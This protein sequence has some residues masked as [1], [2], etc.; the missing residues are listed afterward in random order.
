MPGISP[1]RGGSFARALPDNSPTRV[2]APQPPAAGPRRHGRRCDATRARPGRHVRGRWA[3]RQAKDRSKRSQSPVPERRAL[4]G[5]A[6]RRQGRACGASP[7]DGRQ[8]PTLAPGDLYRPSRPDGEGQARGQA[9]NARGEPPQP[10]SCQGGGDR[11]NKPTS[12]LLVNYHPARGRH[13]DPSR[14]SGRNRNAETPRVGSRT[15]CDFEGNR[16]FGRC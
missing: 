3:G 10:T 11:R 6:L 4:S 2:A 7:G 12:G 9:R 15:C 13:P 5:A 14:V 1:F 8:A 16:L